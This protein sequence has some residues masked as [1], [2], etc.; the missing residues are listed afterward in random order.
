[1]LTHYYHPM[2]RAVTTDWM[3]R[4]LD[5]DHD[6]KVIKDRL[7]N[8]YLPELVEANGEATVRATL[9]SHF[10]S[11]AAFDILVRR[12]RSSRK[13]TRPSSPSASAPSRKRSRTSW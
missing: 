5:A 9:E 2:S 11:P 12:I 4:E 1:M 13:I 8:E 3:L 7:P 6:R 10:I